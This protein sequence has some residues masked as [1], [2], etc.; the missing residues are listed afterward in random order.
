M[1][2]SPRKR[3]KNK[4]VGKINRYPNLFSKYFHNWSIS[5]YSRLEV[6]EDVPDISTVANTIETIE[7]FP[8]LVRT[9]ERIEEDEAE[10]VSTNEMQGSSILSMDDM[11]Q[12]NSPLKLIMTFNCSEVMIY[13][14][15]IIY[16]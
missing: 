2:S 10:E 6:V 5:Y 13:K 12:W 4:D 9:P 16:A 7:T 3:L 14:Y 15:N 11:K 8:K 1:I